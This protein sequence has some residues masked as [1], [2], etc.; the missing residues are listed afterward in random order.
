[1]SQTALF[2]LVVAFVAWF[3]TRWSLRLAPAWSELP[4][5]S[6]LAFALALLV[7]LEPLFGY[8]TGR[9][10]EL[11]AL[12]AAPVYAFMP[13]LAMALARAGRFGAASLLARLLY[14]SP[15]AHAAFGR[16]FAQAAVQLGDADAARRLMPEGDVLLAI[17]AA[18]LAG[19][20]HEVVDMWPEAPRTGDNAFLADEALVVS[21]LSLGRQWE[22]DDAL[23]RARSRFESNPGEQ[24]PIGTRVLV[25]SEARIAAERADLPRVR[26]LLVQPPHGVAA[27]NVYEI[28][29]R[30][31]EKAHRVEE[32][33]ALYTHTYAAA[34]EAARPRLARKL[35]AFD[36]PVPKV[37]R[38][39]AL[40]GTLVLLGS[41]AV[42]YG[43]QELLNATVG[44][45]FTM[46]GQ[47]R[48]SDAAAA[49]LLNITGAPSADA[50]WRYL[51]YALVHG[52]LI[53][54]A[55]NLWV[56][57]DIG[58]VYEA[59]RN[60]GNLLG[61][62]TLG[63][64]MGAYITGIAQAGDVLLLVGAS[65]GVLGVAGAL[66]ADALRSG[67]ASD[68]QLTRSL[69]QWMGLIVL[70][71][72]AVP[73]VSL[74]GHVGGLVGG[75]LWGFIRQGIP[76]SRAFDRAVGFVSVAL[77]LFAFYSA[78]TVALSL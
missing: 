65:G 59:R 4:V 55:F 73:G 50:L 64:I 24:G 54:I 29:A 56:L 16:V 20:H 11:L 72:I 6:L 21:L 51:S 35:E 42:M 31:S 25:L 2:L 26:D 37:A 12:I 43:L 10:L 5:K 9:T 28:F 39:G 15:D 71:S 8:R 30:A 38:R 52:N 49:F 66:L 33:A 45:V 14:W 22:A 3:T 7:A 67:L 61:A 62:F 27:W 23:Q 34:P 70:L 44:N 53:H 41:L 58:R 40:P 75:L 32:A 76:V 1:M 13:L 77:L 74:W 36:R 78:V 17:Q 47:M 63:S 46:A 19:D 48:A 57:F 69:V 60:W 18:V 68:R